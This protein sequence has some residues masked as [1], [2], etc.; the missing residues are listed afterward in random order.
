MSETITDGGSVPKNH[1]QETV[2]GLS[3]PMTSPEPERSSSDPD[4]LRA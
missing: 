4:T 3:R 1:L 2:Y